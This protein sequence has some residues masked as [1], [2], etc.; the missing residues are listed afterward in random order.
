[1]TAV[2]FQRRGD[3]T[4]VTFSYNAEI[5]DTIKRIVPA[6]LRPWDPARREWVVHEPAYVPELAAVLRA[7]GYR[8]VGLDEPSRDVSCQGWAHHLFAAVGPKRHTTVY[9]A[10]SRC[11]HPDVGGDHQ[12]MQTLN[13]A[14]AEIDKRRTA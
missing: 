6:F 13:R 9:R 11:L 3:A 12:L 7:A 4:V 2:R 10:L 8:V 1:V 14:Y 5:V